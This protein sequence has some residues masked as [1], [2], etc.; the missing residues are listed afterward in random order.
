MRLIKNKKME[1]ITDAKKLENVLSALG[2]SAHSFSVEME[3]KSPQS[4]YH[5]LNGVNSLSQG[6]KERIIKVYPNVN[7]NY[8]SDKTQLPIL[9]T[10][11]DLQSQMNLFNI[12]SQEGQDFLKFKRLMEIPERLDKIEANQGRLEARIEELLKKL[13]EI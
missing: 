8:L 13:G 3:Y 9:L 2:K 11:G 10:G 5:V 6:M 4:V 1:D 12:P 7:T